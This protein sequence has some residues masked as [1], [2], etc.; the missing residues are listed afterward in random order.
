MPPACV[1]KEFGRVDRIERSCIFE[2]S[3]T[4]T[5]SHVVEVGIAADI[6]QELFQRWDD[7]AARL[8]QGR[9]GYQ[10]FNNVAGL[11]D[12]DVVIEDFLVGPMEDGFFSFLEAVE[13][14]FC[15]FTLCLDVS[16]GVVGE[17][18]LERCKQ[19]AFV[20]TEGCSRVIFFKALIEDGIG[21]LLCGDEGG[22]RC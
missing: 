6:D 13:Q 19:G 7:D 10:R 2:H 21:V 20:D 11:G 15:K 22:F 1:P 14:C 4:L 12:V 3:E 5:T 9:A 16:D 8:L 18:M 17:M